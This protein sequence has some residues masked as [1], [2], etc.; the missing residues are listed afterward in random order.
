MDRNLK[1]GIVGLGLIGGS[2][3]K[4]LCALKC[5]VY[6][7]SKSNPTL[8]KA[9]EYSQNV[10]KSLLHLKECD[11]I[12]VCTPINKT[13][14]VLDKL[15]KILEPH[16]I[17][18]DVAS[19]KRFVSK[20]KRPY[21]F[22]PSHP[23]AGTELSGFDSSFESLFQ[24]SKWVFTPFD[25][26]Q[27]PDIKKLID[28]IEVLGA[29]P[30]FSTPEMHD[31][32]VSLISHMPMLI[33]QALFKSGGEKKLALKLASSGFRDMTRLALSNEEMAND[34]ITMN[35]DNIQTALLKLYSSVGEL[36]NPDY[37]KKIA[38]IKKDRQAMY[39]NGKNV[40]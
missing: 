5:D 29:E 8:L 34:M 15:D 12:F 33:A 23:M 36:L 38:S 30:V 26:T 17:V 27:D 3:F 10:S 39:I 18:T 4:A 19:L 40:L 37:A 2:I 9:K 31:E 24:G 20:K 32:A 7:S 13:L 21:K 6:A 16:T 28:V 1:I 14:E 35:S 25:D 11:I 22:I